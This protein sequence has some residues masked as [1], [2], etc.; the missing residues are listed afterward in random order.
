MRVSL[1]GYSSKAKPLLLTL[2]MG[3][4]LSAA[5]TPLCRAV[6][7]P[8]AAP[9]PHLPL[10]AQPPCPLSAPTILL[11]FLLPWMWGSSSPPLTTLALHSHCWT[12]NSEEAEVEQ[13]YEYVQ[14][15]SELT[16]KKR[17]PFHYR[18]LECKSRKS[19]NTWS[20]KHIWP[21]S[22]E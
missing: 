1:H 10:A 3:Y 22:T 13:Y 18:G 11:A 9:A 19:G 2:D 6:Q 8:L 20:N 21:W 17:C 7:L 5:P 12:S 15:L 14:G 4:L 16:P